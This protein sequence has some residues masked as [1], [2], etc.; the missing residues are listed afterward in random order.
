MVWSKVIDYGK[1]GIV[2]KVVKIS[3]L[4]IWGIIFVMGDGR[5]VK[6]IL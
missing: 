4:L 5:L 2:N 1:F 6:V 3:N